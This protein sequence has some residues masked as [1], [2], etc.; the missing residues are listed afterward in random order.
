MMDCP[1]RIA[2]ALLDADKRGTSYV[3]KMQTNANTFLRRNVA[4]TRGLLIPKQ[5][6]LAISIIRHLLNQK[7]KKKKE[8]AHY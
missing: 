6:W 8:N 7:K 4:L 3:R 5:Q 2:V 1:P